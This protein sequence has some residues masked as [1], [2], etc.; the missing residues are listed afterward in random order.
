MTSIG[1]DAMTGKSMLRDIFPLHTYDQWREAVDKQLKGAPFEKKL[2][3]GTYEGIEI[4]P[5]Y[6]LHDVEDLPHMGSLPGTP[7]FVRGTKVLGHVV[8]PWEISQEIGYG[9]PAEHNRAAGADLKRGQTA[10]NMVLDRA[11]L[12]GLDPARAESGQVG[13][14]GLS[15]ATVDD[16]AATF[17]GIDLEKTPLFI[18]AGPSG[19]PVAALVAAFL[20]RDKKSTEKLRGC[21]GSDPLASLGI[22]GELLLSLKESY[23]EMAGLTLWAKENAPR[24]RTMAVHGNQYHDAGAGAVQELAFAMATGVEYLREMLSRGISIDDAAPRVCFSFSVGSDFFMEMAK[25]RAARL[26]WERVVDAFGGNN[27]SKRLFMHVRTSWWNKTVTDPY[28]NMLRVTTEAFA[29]ICGGC[30]SLYVGAFD[31]PV[32]PPDEF[33]RRIAR[34]VQIILKNESHLNSVVDPGGGSWYTEVLTDAIAGKAW[35]LFQQVEKKGGMLKAL[36]QGFP[37]E[38]A[39][40]TALRRAKNIAVRKDVFVGTNK[41][42]NLIEKPIEKA[43]PDYEVFHKERSLCVAQYQASVDPD[44]LK[45]ALDHLIQG[46]DRTAG[47][48]VKNAIAAVTAGATLGQLTG[49]L[50]SKKSIKGGS[51][52][53]SKPTITPLRIQRGAAMF[54]SLR[55]AADGHVKKTGSRPKVFLANMGPIPQHKPRADFS[56]DF[57]STGGFGIIGNDGFQDI[58]AAAEAAVKSGANIAVICSTDKTYPDIVPPLCRGIKEIK[59]G[60]TV[61]VAGYPKD[62]IDAFKECGVDD[63][64]HIRSNVL[65]MLEKLQKKAGVTS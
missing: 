56:T 2:V 40:E 39:A 9:D 64:I 25:L 32:G 58:D 6:F 20:Q 53:G 51:K 42:P 49:A 7:P 8:D 34:N 31:E 44:K 28:V 27:A 22:E 15:I 13:R 63:F 41:Y 14:G 48:V 16:V 55:K 12:S 62:Y 1:T 59:P 5:M 50:R 60:M 52:E 10:L 43:D 19:L 3:K 17:D 21:I 33:S 38:Q 61:L 57:F 30:D 65:D 18:Y 54:E 36:Q 26:L 35:R 11:V 4:Q 46:A 24:L 29:A 47:G 45:E 37:Q 23:D